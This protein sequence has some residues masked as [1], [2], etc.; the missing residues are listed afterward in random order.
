[1]V[2]KNNFS[3]QMSKILV[4][5]KSKGKINSLNEFY[6]SIKELKTRKKLKSNFILM[7]KK[8]AV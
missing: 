5:Y 3:S 1:M 2:K 4:H 7:K 8:I 6:N